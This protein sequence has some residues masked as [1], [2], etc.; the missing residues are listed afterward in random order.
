MG[1]NEAVKAM[2]VYVYNHQELLLLNGEPK[3]RNQAGLKESKYRNLAAQIILAEEI[4]AVYETSYGYFKANSRSQVKK[5]ATIDQLERL[6][7]VTP[8]TLEYIASHPEQLKA[9]NSDIGVRIGNRVYQPQKTLVLQNVSSHDI[10]ENRVV[11]GFLRKMINEVV[12]LKTRCK[13]LLQQIPNDEDY[14]SEYIYSSFFM[15]SETR[16]M[17]ETGMRQLSRLYDKFSLLWGM[18]RDALT[19]PAEQ[20]QLTS[21]PRPTAIF[22]SVPQYNKIF[23]RIHQWSNFGIYN[24]DKEK[25][26]LSL[27][28]ISAL[29]ENYLLAKTVG[30]FKDSGYTFQKSVRCAYP[31]SPRSKYKNTICANTFC[32]SGG[33]HKIT[34]YY[35][36]VIFS[37]DR[38]SVNGIGLYRNN[39]IP[40]GTGEDDDNRQGGYYYAPDYIIKVDNAGLS[41]YLIIDAKFS[42][43][44]TVRRYYVEKLA[45]KY[46]FSIS[47]VQNTDS[48][49]GIC[50]IYGKCTEQ[51]QSQSIYDNQIPGNTIIPFAETIPMIEG[52]SSGDQYNK[53]NMLIQKLLR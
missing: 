40:V 43:I 20:E 38:S 47:P 22:M 7:Y 34:L 35:Q 19:I 17:L 27:I 29:Y 30:F 18:Y 21:T 5:A 3:P 16:R 26:M 42:D 1:I 31:I 45:F 33:E 51:D 52:V 39:S 28:K 14:S 13:S 41:K 2:V 37:T 15:F 8:A 23:V 9:V 32:F 44:Q 4:A 46:L 12:E 25:F 24:F 6:Q 10:Y 36:P 11:L 53:L 48:L 49:A 50:I